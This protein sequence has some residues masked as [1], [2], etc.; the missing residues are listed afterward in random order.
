M[1]RPI[2]LS[3]K[4]RIAMLERAIE[5]ASGEIQ[6]AE[7]SGHSMLAASMRL[8]L[9]HTRAELHAVLGMKEEEDVQA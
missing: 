9:K 5:F 7:A 4:E 1:S 2:R 8:T 6:K 3:K